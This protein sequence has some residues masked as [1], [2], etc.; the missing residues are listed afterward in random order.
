[1]RRGTILILGVSVLCGVATG[2]TVAT[3]TYGQ[4]RS[5]QQSYV[6]DH[7]EIDAVKR[8]ERKLD[9]ISDA[10]LLRAYS[11]ERSPSRVS[12]PT[13]ALSDTAVASTGLGLGVLLLLFVGLHACWLLGRAFN[14]VM[15]RL[16]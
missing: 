14:K 5:E 9:S 6:R 15:D 16:S 3:R 7:L 12:P 4:C 2:T 11:E 1:M 13:C 10:A 8:G